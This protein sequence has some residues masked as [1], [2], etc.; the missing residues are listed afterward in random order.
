MDDIILETYSLEQTFAEAGYD[1]DY[2]AE[3][4]LF[5]GHNT[6]VLNDAE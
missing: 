1:Y 6:K 2:P 3:Q 4:E 5:L